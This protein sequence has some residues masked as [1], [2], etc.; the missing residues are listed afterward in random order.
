MER[1]TRTCDFAVITSTGEQPDSVIHVVGFREDDGI[2]VQAHVAGGLR[3]HVMMVCEIAKS[4]GKAAREKD[5][6]IA[7]AAFV[8][9]IADAVLEGV[10]SEAV[11]LAGEM[12]KAIT[13]NPEKALKA[14]LKAAKDELG[15][16]EDDDEDDWGED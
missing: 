3:D 4:I 9:S 2:E 15:M 10:G 14:L 12:L 13:M 8:N 1:N 5:G 7:A 16:D 6:L 11:E